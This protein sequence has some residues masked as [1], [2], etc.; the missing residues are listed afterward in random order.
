MRRVADAGLGRGAGGGGGGGAAGGRGGGAGGGGGGGG[1]DAAVGGG[2]GRRRNRWPP[3]V[4]MRRT[5]PEP[6]VGRPDDACLA[7]YRGRIQA[8]G[9]AEGICVPVGVSRPHD[10][11]NSRLSRRP[12]CL[13]DPL[14]MNSGTSSRGKCTEDIM[15]LRS[16]MRLDTHFG[17]TNGAPRG[18]GGCRRTSISDGSADACA[19]LRRRNRE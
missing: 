8:D 1:R 15:R 19:I 11:A 16:A 6:R 7:V 5:F 17:I 14:Q 12:L 18:G 2:A 9:G 3:Q 10:G 4:G 13:L